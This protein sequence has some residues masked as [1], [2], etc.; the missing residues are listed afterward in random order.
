[1]SN[2]PA[3]ICEEIVMNNK[4]ILRRRFPEKRK[5]KTEEANALEELGKEL[6][7]RK[8]EILS[9][10]ETMQKPVLL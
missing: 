6:D 10:T 8:D 2:S 4:K 9:D 3:K 5:P 1:M 7:S